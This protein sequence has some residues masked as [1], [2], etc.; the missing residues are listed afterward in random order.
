V[1]EEAL[2]VEAARLHESLRLWSR[3]RL[4][5]VLDVSPRTL[6]RHEADPAC[7]LFGRELR[8]R[9]KAAIVYDAPAVAAYRRWLLEDPTR[10]AS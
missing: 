5:D 10:L 2:L 7:P 6:T 1:S 3:K 4:R 9:G 8:P